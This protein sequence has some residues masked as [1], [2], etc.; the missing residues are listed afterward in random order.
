MR[1]YV[2]VAAHLQ[3]MRPAPTSE[4]DILMLKENSNINTIIQ[5]LN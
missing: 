4:K 2:A 1:G 3:G 5:T